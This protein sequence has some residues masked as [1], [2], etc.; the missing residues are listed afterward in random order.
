MKQDI[1]DVKQRI[2]IESD[3]E[4]LLAKYLNE[5]TNQFFNRGLK[6][7]YAIVSNF[8]TLLLEKI[9]E[10]VEKGKIT[11]FEIS[12]IIEGNGSP[13]D[14]ANQYI[15][16]NEIELESR[17]DTKT[18]LQEISSN[19]EQTDEISQS[20]NNLDIEI[21]D[22]IFS[23]IL[24]SLIQ[25]ALGAAIIFVEIWISPVRVS[26]RVLDGFYLGIQSGLNQGTTPGAKI[27]KGIVGAYVGPMKGFVSGFEFTFN[28]MGEGFEIIGKGFEDFGKSLYR[29][30]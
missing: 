20:T 18:G 22:G 25:I 17:Y 11:Q 12:R 3:G 16:I 9:A 1:Q 14:V 6:D 28:K 10:R 27:L 23:R 15:E 2:L 24:D 30:R 26:G 19:I 13:A 21:T 8:E 29:S 4:K 5:I 7:S